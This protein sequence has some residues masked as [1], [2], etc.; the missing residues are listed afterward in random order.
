MNDVLERMWKI[1]HGLLYTAIPV[2][3]GMT[4]LSQ[5]SPEANKNFNETH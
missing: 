1:S 4:T 2:F 3:A 5:E